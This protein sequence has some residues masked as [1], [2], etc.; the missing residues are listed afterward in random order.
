MIAK[1]PENVKGQDGMEEG[2]GKK[3]A[4]H[5]RGSLYGRPSRLP[6]FAGLPANAVGRHAHMPPE[7]GA[8]WSGPGGSGGLHGRGVGTPPYEVK[9]SLLETRRCGPGA[10]KMRPQ[11]GEKVFSPRCAYF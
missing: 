11:R 7:P 4:A 2:R 5:R 10:Y 9:S 1:P 3:C 6:I 8:I